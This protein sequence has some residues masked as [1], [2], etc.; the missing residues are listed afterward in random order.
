M[1]KF[2]ITIFI[3]ALQEGCF[4]GT[5]QT[6]QSLKPGDVDAGWYVSYPL[7]FNRNVKKRSEE[8][9]IGSYDSRPN[10]GGF[11]AYGASPS[12]DFGLWGSLG[13]GFGPFGKFQFLGYNRLIP[14]PIDGALWAGF[15][16]HPIVEGIIGKLALIGSSQLSEYSTL[17]FGWI[18]VNSPDYRKLSLP[19]DDNFWTRL[20]NLGSFKFFHAIFL[21]IDLYRKETVKEEFR[22]LPF[23]ISMEFTLPLVTYPALFFGI[24]FRK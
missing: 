21:G 5:F 2:L 8:Q 17:Y 14:S 23:G 18:G 1:R 7:Y 10:V 15:S 12:T 4:F 6:A 9:G 24:Q 19:S 20:R 11:I 16:Y 22:R 13:E 3:A